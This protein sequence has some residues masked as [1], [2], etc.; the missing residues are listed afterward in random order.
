VYSGPGQQ[1]VPV[2]DDDGN[3]IAIQPAAQP[4]ATPSLA[5]PPIIPQ[6]TVPAA[7]PSAAPVP[8]MTLP[9]QMK[10]QPT[11][12]EEDMETIGKRG[13]KVGKKKNLNSSI[14]RA[15]RNI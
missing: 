9:S 7:A 1:G 5:T 4:A 2:L 11:P 12:F 8:M 13:V 6:G 14:V 10:D 3:V 15:F